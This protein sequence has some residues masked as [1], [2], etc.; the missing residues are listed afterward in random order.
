MP[1]ENDFGYVS[2]E[3]SNVYNA[4]INKY[5]TPEEPENKK[6]TNCNISSTEVCTWINRI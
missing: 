6:V 4:I 2:K 1:D 5:C 3:S